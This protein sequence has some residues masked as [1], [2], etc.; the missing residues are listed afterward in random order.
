MSQNKPRRMRT[1]RWLMVSILVAMAAWAAG[2]QGLDAAERTVIRLA[3]GEWPPYTGLHL[4][5][6]GCDSQVVTEAFGLENIRV[7][8]EFLPWARG[9]MLSQN[10]AV[11]GAVEW[12]GTAE[13]R[14]THFVSS[15][16][17]SNQ[18]WVFFHRKDTE[19]SW[20]RLDDLVGRTIGLTIGYAYSDLFVSLRQRHPE[21]FKEAASDLLNF[22]KLLAGRIDLFPVERAVGL[23]VIGRDLHARDR[24]VL[25]FS[26]QALAEFRPYLLLSRALPANEERMRLFDRGLRRLKDNGRY[27]AIMSPCRADGS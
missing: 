20:H 26:P 7:E 24:E 15:E 21:M 17:L 5:G 12:A 8:Y 23:H 10:G 22:K 6:H 13:Q 4:P 18:Q 25:V 19:V 11:D 3:N 2:G 14:R 27:D 1:A 16:P 9:L